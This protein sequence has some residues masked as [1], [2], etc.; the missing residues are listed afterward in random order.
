MSGGRAVVANPETWRW[1]SKG[2]MTSGMDE[3]SSAR[4][5]EERKDET[6]VDLVCPCRGPELR[7]REHRRLLHPLLVF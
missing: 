1:I 5:D 7:S 2:V 6:N 4:E 3:R